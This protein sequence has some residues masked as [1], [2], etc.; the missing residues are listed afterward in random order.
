MTTDMR[1]ETCNEFGSF[2]VMG[3]QESGN[4]HHG[5]G[6]RMTAHEAWLVP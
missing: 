1:Q 5:G 4:H 3:S 6:K 2:D